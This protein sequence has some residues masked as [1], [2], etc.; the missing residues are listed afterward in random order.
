M[1]FRDDQEQVYCWSGYFARVNLEFPS[2]YQA[3]L[4]FTRQQHANW[5]D[6]PACFQLSNSINATEHTMAEPQRRTVRVPKSVEQIVHDAQDFDRK[7]DYPL[8]I[9]L[10]TAQNILNQVSQGPASQSNKTDCLHRQLAMNAMAIS[11]M[12]TFSSIGMP[13]SV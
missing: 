8:K 3:A 12:P 13:S 1:A 4:G 7:T 9:A 6:T 5:L 10:R 2:Q 11:K